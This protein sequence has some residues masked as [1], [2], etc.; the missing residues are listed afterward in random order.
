MNSLAIIS[1]TYLS[2]IRRYDCNF[3]AVVT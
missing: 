1:A 2:Q 3:G